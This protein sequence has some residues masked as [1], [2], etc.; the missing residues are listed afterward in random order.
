MIG[1]FKKM[2]RSAPGL[3]PCLPARSELVEY[4]N[5]QWLPYSPDYWRRGGFGME[6]ADALYVVGRKLADELN[7]PVTS[8][9]THCLVPA[10]APPSGSM[11]RCGPTPP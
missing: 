6:L 1:L 10:V 9:Y 4:V 7:T 8:L 11:G 3:E 5:G 2:F